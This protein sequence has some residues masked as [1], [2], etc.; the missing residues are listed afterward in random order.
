MKGHS[1][2]PRGFTLIEIIVTIVIAAIMGVVVYQYL[3][4][5]MVRSSEPLF[6]LQT[7]K[8]LHQV[9]ENISADY[10]RYYLQDLEGL[11]DKIDQGAANPELVGYGV[12]SV[13]ASH[14]IVFDESNVGQPIGDD[15]GGDENED[16]DERILKVTIRNVQ[17][18]T[19]TMLFIR[20][21]D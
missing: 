15:D 10:R 14:Y 9:A 5:S 11:K 7:S 6:R 2:P 16:A 1:G 20:L 13:A 18:E 8:A 4:V 17:N 21:D 19:L 12:Y 3:Q